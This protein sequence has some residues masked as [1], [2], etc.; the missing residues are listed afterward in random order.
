M[1]RKINLTLL[2]LNILFGAIFG[3]TQLYVHKADIANSKIVKEIGA[4]E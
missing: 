4:K 2:A 1:L 3:A